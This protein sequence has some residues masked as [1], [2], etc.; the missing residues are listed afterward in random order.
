MDR[1]YNLN[2]L[3]MITG[4]T[5]RTLRTYLSRGLLDGEKGNGVW[6]FSAEDV[7]RFLNEPF[8]KEG[9]RIKR[10]AVVFDFLAETSKKSGRACVILDLPVGILEGQ[11]ISNFF[12]EQM[13]RATDATFCSGM[14][15]GVFRVILSGDRAQVAQIMKNYESME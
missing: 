2:E 12:C 8:V 14:D 13:C 3:A 15:G 7:E 1:T 11:K 4:F 9:L 5:T 10:N 6:Q